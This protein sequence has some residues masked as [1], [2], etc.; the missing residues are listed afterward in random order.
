MRGRAADWWTPP[1]LP[2]ACL[3]AAHPTPL[4][5]GI[6]I[7]GVEP[8]DTPAPAQPSVPGRRLRENSCDICVIGG[9]YNCGC[10][11]KCNQ[12]VEDVKEYYDL[13]GYCA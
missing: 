2:P 4:Q 1:H 5:A 3:P 6:T 9:L 8:A 10:G 12:M 13:Y 11:K 7:F